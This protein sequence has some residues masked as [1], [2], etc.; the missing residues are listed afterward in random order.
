MQ[1]DTQIAFPV[2]HLPSQSINQ[3]PVMVSVQLEQNKAPTVSRLNIYFRCM[4]IQIKP[5][6]EQ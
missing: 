5:K 2:A 3:L 4:H 1:R 6:E